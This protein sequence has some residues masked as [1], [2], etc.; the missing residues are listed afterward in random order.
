M[1]KVF[2]PNQIIFADAILQKAMKKLTKMSQSILAVV[3]ENYFLLGVITDGDIRRALLNGASLEE[4]VD[5]FYN[6][7]PIIGS[8]LKNEFEL[9][10]LMKEKSI[11]RLP[12]VDADG[13]F[14]R[15]EFLE[16]RFIPNAVPNFSGEEIQY[17]SKAINS[18]FIAVGPDIEKFENLN[19]VTIPVV[20]LPLQQTQ[21]LLLFTFH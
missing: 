17:L 13:V 10:Q 14:F 1:K 12:V 16:R 2:E 21:A 20:N 19:F 11:D 15:F 4:Q 9:R 3:D 6:R 8:V 7:K 5:R 18:N